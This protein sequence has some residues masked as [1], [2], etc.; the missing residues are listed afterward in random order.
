MSGLAGGMAAGLLQVLNII[1][2]MVEFVIIAAALVSWVSPD[3]R[4][5]IVQFLYRFTEPIFRPL[6]R[7]IPPRL[8]GGLD[9]SP[10]LA[11]LILIFI[12]ALIFSMLGASFRMF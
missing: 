4:N 10:L 8:T 1:F 2:T 7:I 3:P 9:F 5:P 6:R 11:I 12:R